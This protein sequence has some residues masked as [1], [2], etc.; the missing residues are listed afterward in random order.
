[1]H[2]SFALI[3]LWVTYQWGVTANAGLRGIIFGTLVLFAVFGCVLLHEL[4][5][6]TVAMRFGLTV[7][8]ITLLPI[9]G[10]ARVEQVALLPR[11]EALIALAGPATNV[12]IAIVL[13]PVVAL[14][15]AAKHMSEPLAILLFADQLSI[16]G[17]V[18][19]LWIANV[20]LALFNLLPAFPMDGGRV[21]RALLTLFA[22]R[23]QAT[24]LAVLAGQILATILAVIGVWIGDYL[25]PIVSLFIL[26]AAWMEARHV[27]IE[28]LLHRLPVGQF[29]LWEEGGIRPDAPLVHAIRG[30]PRDMAVT[31]G[32][33]V[34][35][36]LW[37]R[38]MLRQLNGA[39]YDLSVRDVMDHRATV[40]DVADSIYDV[41]LLLL[42]ANR[43]AVAVVEDGLYRGIFTIERL[44]HVYEHLDDRGSRWARGLLSLAVRGRAY[45]TS[46]TR[47]R[48][49]PRFPARPRVAKPPPRG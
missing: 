7:R 6:A 14:V 38:D 8:D 44:A 48:V 10:V 20:L 31:S 36:M 27:Q 25:L 18:L 46:L 49:S 47:P 37:R 17:F 22:N 4:A 5:H 9:G 23:L 19:Y 1:V 12:A 3:V 32:G 16:A 33:A 13:T 24:R 29:A 15:L 26:V 2:P 35:G 21:L 42:A 45:V 34:V 41:H 28:W 40:V 11:A 43:S 30:G 39:H